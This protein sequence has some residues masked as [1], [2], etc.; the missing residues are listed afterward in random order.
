[1]HPIERMTGKGAGNGACRTRP[2][3]LRRAGGRASRRPLSGFTGRVF[4]QE[5]RT[6]EESMASPDAPDLVIFCS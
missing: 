4:T 3:S 2:T 6:S 5:I 1:M